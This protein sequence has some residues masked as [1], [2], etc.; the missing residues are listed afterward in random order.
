[1]RRT[2]SSSST[3]PAAGDG[4]ALALVTYVLHTHSL[5]TQMGGDASSSSF[6]KFGPGQTDRNEIFL[7]LIGHWAKKLVGPKTT[8]L[9]V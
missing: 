6:V 1:M 8:F 9:H 2:S 7:L 3:R 4:G 5:L